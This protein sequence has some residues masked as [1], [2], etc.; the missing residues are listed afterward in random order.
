VTGASSGIGFHT[1][2]VSHLLLP[3]LSLP[4]TVSFPSFHTARVNQALLLNIRGKTVK[5]GVAKLVQG[6]SKLVLGLSQLGCGVGKV[7]DA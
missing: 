4:L 3:L 7:S 6:V 2:R 5:H 1:A